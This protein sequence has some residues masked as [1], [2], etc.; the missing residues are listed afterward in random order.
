MMDDGIHI[1]CVED[2]IDSCDLLI[3]LF[4]YHKPAYDV[5]GSHGFDDA[6]G[7]IKSGSHHLYILDVRI[8]GR[9]G[10]ELIGMIREQ[11][12][13]VPIIAY[14]AI[15]ERDEKKAAIDAGANAFLSKPNDFDRIVPTAEQLLHSRT[16]SAN[17]QT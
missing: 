12:P 5:T 16:L 6:V 8:A 14:S 15:V 4:K 1:L 17:L 11:N 10:I 7:K 13:T 2:D 9:S 3:H